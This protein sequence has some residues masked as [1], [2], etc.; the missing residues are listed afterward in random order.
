MTAG[1]GEASRILHTTDGGKRWTEQHRETK[2]ES[3]LDGFDSGT[4]RAASRTAT[5][6]KTVASA[7]S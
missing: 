1:P 4:G 3:F 6:W 7:C 2:P 5:R